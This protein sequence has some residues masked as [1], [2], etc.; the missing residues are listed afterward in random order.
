MGAK[1]QECG[2][3]IPY[4]LLQGSWTHCRTRTQYKCPTCRC[5]EHGGMCKDH[6]PRKPYINRALLHYIETTSLQEI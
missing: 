4:L 6:K 2:K 3:A 5:L 1:E